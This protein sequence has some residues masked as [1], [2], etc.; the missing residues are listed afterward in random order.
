MPEKTETSLYDKY[1]K[2]LKD[3]IYIAGILF[4]IYGWISEKAKNKVRF[5]SAI[6]LNTKA[7]ENNTSALEK[8]NRYLFEQNKLNGQV[9]E[10]MNNHK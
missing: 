7:T 4:A 10:Y 8:V 5:E 1:F 9:I 6:E 3:V 2:Y